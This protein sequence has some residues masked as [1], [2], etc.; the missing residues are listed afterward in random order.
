MI[1]L[2]IFGFV[3]IV[4]VLALTNPGVDAHKAV[5]YASVAKNSIKNELLGKIAADVLDHIDALPITYNNYLF[6]ST[7][8]I[9]GERAS[10]GLFSH[11][12]KMD[13]STATTKKQD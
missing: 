9:Q 8:T 1:R 5:V 10:V 6:F 4:V 11:V 7:T 12:W 13:L 2:G 3:V